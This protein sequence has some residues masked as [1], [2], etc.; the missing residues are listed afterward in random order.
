MF[1]CFAVLYCV[2]EKLGKRKNQSFGRNTVGFLMMVHVC[3]QCITDQQFL[4]KRNSGV[5]QAPYSPASLIGHFPVFMNES[6]LKSMWE[7]K[8]KEHVDQI[9][10]NHVWN[11]GKNEILN[12]IAVLMQ[13]WAFLEGIMFNKIYVLHFIF[14]L[15]SPRTF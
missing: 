5:P 15:I 3:T 10:S 6:F 7:C 9:P 4:P 13:K 12:G 1:I 11:C 2:F 8:K 14:Y